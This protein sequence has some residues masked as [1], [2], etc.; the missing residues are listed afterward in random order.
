MLAPL[1]TPGLVP[2][3]AGLIG[4]VVA[5]TLRWR[6]DVVLG[7]HASFTFFFLAV[8]VA[9]WT[10]GVWPAVATALLS[11][12]VGNYFFSHPLGSFY[13]SG[14]EEFISLLI[15][16]AVSVVI[17]ML[18]E[19]SRR[20]LHRAKQAERAK[21]TFLATLAHE[22]RS[23]LSVIQYA[24]ELN[25]ITATTGSYNQVEIIEH[26]VRQLDLM[27][28]DLLDVSRIARG[29]MRLDRRHLDASQIVDGAV[30]KAKPLI[31]SHDHILKVE[32]P[33]QPIPIYVDSV[34]I[35][36]VLA[37]LLINAAKYTPE[38]GRI[39]LRLEAVDEFAV[40][41]V[42]DN[43]IGISAEALPHVFELFVQAEPGSKSAA[44]GLGI[45][46]ALV[47]K[48]VELHGGNV[49]AASAGK[50]RGTEFTVSLPLDRP[51]PAP[52]ASKSAARPATV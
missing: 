36:Q 22:L 8:S 46:L 25:R 27:I 40:F 38:G 30:L 18:A 19:T 5:G 37:N 35:E 26:Q 31:T 33:P 3:A 4:V 9:A 10:G 47:R 15:F 39:N 20:A 21:D 41:S 29:K 11:C 2:Y 23:P 16:L 51:A 28:Q 48:V 44:D 6:Y 32:V 14:H 34:R 50:N 17:G 13:I 52:L 7:N 24:N 45:G 12:L 42:R 43:G 49:R 1:R